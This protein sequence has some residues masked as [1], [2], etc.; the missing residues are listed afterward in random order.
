[1][2]STKQFQ[3]HRDED[4]FMVAM[5]A[6]NSEIGNTAGSPILSVTSHVT[7]RTVVFGLDKTNYDLEG[8]VTSWQYKSE[9]LPGLDVEIWND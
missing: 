8:D 4:G 5:T 9:D 3:F 6:D 1:M 2:L 7:G